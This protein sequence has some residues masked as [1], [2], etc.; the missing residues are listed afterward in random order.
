MGMTISKLPSNR[1]MRTKIAKR[2]FG[3]KS[4]VTQIV[5]GKLLNNSSS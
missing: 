3:G 5:S 4:K 2:I 1:S